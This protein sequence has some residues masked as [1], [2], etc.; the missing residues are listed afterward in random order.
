VRWDFG[1]VPLNTELPTMTFDV[2]IPF[3]ALSGETF[4][5]EA[6]IES[7]SDSSDQVW[8]DSQAGL[9]AVQ[10]V[11]FTAGKSVLTPVIPED[12]TVIYQLG[13][14]NVSPDRTVPWFDAI[15]ILPFNGDFEGSSFGGN[16]SNVDVTSLPAGIV[17]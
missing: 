8:R 15:D 13:V 16:F 12:G 14:A 4:T 7:A 9:V 3:D 11:A 2:S 10:T 5:N 6:Y 17:R 1:D